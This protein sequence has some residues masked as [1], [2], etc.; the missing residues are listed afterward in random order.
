MEPIRPVNQ[1]TNTL[2]WWGDLSKRMGTIRLGRTTSGLIETDGTHPSRES[3][4]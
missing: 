2:I 1:P 4:H 3:A